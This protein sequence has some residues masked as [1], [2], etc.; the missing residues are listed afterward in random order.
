MNLGKPAVEVDGISRGCQLLMK[1]AVQ[2]SLSGV[3][4]RLQQSGAINRNVTGWPLTNSS[5]VV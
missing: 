1:V 2:R 5:L 4:E 3:V